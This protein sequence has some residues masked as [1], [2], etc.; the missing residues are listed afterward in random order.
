MATGLLTTH[1]GVVVERVEHDGESA[2][3]FHI[4]KHGPRAALL[5]GEPEGLSRQKRRE[6]KF[7]TKTIFTCQTHPET[8]IHLTP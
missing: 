8:N 5:L 6:R 4:A 1:L 2:E 3:V 7:S